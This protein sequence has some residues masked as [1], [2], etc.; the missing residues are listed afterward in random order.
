MILIIALFIQFP[1]GNNLFDRKVRA[2]VFNKTG[3]GAKKFIVS[4]L[5]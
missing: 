4:C 2:V 5:A 1:V 3:K